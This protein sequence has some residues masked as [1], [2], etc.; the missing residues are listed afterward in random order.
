MPVLEKSERLAISPAP[1]DE[2]GF[3]DLTW[4]YEEDEVVMGVP[5]D[6]FHCLHQLV[7]M[8]ETGPVEW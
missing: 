8:V 7:T 5:N 1:V 2:V 6:V 3:S 4:L